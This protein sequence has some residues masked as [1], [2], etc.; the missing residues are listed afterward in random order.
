MA[1]EMVTAEILGDEHPEAQGQHSLMS[2]PPVGPQ[3]WAP[4]R[5]GS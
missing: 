2:T 1:S 5:Q 3:R 4:I